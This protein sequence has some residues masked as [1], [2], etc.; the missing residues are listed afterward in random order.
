M[1]DGEAPEMLDTQDNTVLIGSDV[2]PGC[3]YGSNNYS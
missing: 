1:I 2:G 3:T